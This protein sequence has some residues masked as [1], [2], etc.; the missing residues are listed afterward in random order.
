V[1][2][3]KAGRML[4]A[5]ELMEHQLVIAKHED[6]SRIE[7]ARIVWTGKSSVGL[8]WNRWRKRRKAKVVLTTKNADGLLLDSAGKCIFVWEYLNLDGSPFKAVE[9]KP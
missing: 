5:D 2:R 7:A 4:V 9:P 8:T 1:K 6:N 3:N